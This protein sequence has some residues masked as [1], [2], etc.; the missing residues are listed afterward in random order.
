M[1][2]R[3]FLLV[4]WVSIGLTACAPSNSEPLELPTRVIVATLP[5]LAE[6]TP[7]PN[8]T[9]APLPTHEPNP[10]VIAV[11]EVALE[12]TSTPEIT[13]E[14]DQPA[15]VPSNTITNTPT[16]EPTAT[17]T[18][19][20]EPIAVH[21][22]AELALELTI[23]LPTDRPY[24]TNTPVVIYQSTDPNNPWAIQP[25][26]PVQPNQPPACP[27]LP[28]GAFA[29]VITNNPALT[30]TIGCPIG[31]PPLPITYSGALQTFER[32]VMLWVGTMPSS[33]YVLFNDGTM[34]RYDDTFVQGVDPDDIGQ[35][36]PPGL[37][38]PI[39]GF[40]KIWAQNPTVQSGLGWATQ[41]EQG[42]DIHV[43]EFTHGRMIQVVAQ[44]RIYILATPS[45][46]WQS[47]AP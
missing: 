27:Y 6:A 18:E 23:V 9:E 40:G 13:S 19:T 32:G 35:T 20:T 14:P 44:N 31:E 2:R 39:R 34:A 11:T 45:N 24:V 33:I 38:A 8:E 37:I 41:G 21:F 26:Q 46:T 5:P 47:A 1:T 43:H 16:R 17:P 25:V 7:L 30:G 3:L 22:L 4:L 42:T 15:V 36:A 12:V 28:A 10:E 29:N